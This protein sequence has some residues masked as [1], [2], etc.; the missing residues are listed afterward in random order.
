MTIKNFSKNQICPFG[1]EY[2]VYWDLRYSTLSRFDECRVD[3]TALYTMV[4]EELALGMAR[5]T[6]GRKVVDLCSG[7]GCMSIAFA[8]AGKKVIGVEI[9][10][11]RAAMARHNAGVYGVAASIEVL[12]ADISD[13]AT[14]AALPDDTE[15][16]FMD[17]PWGTG[18]GE[19]LRHRRKYLADLRLGGMDLRDIVRAIPCQEVVMRFPPNFD[20]EIFRDTPGDKLALTTRKGLLHFYVL[21]TSKEEFLKIPDRS[22]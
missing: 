8:R 14:L 12:A 16:V 13:P 10:A 11:E 9:D 22:D 17:P 20:F 15:A 19:Y 4:W 21:R 6:R 3:A 18:P 1:P 7:V 5:L 2:Q